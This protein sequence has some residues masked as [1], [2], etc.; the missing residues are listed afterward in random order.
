[1]DFFYSFVFF[2]AFL[3]ALS[4]LPVIYSSDDNHNEFVQLVVFASLKVKS[5]AIGKIRRFHFRSSSHQAKLPIVI[6]ASSLTNALPTPPT[7]AIRIRHFAVS[8]AHPEEVAAFVKETAAAR[9]IQVAYRTWYKNKPVRALPDPVIIT[10]RRKM[11]RP[12]IKTPEDRAMEQWRQ[13]NQRYFE[14]F[15]QKLEETRKARRAEFEYQQQSRARLVV[16]REEIKKHKELDERFAKWVEQGP[17]W[18]KV[19]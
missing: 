9:L 10:W 16:L 8:Y 5:F 3:C 17:S 12:P 11:G 2:I 18:L 15:D 1:M 6:T 13:A 19:V 7:E 14:E 4:F